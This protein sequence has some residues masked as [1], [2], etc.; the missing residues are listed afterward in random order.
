MNRGVYC[1]IG[2]ARY[3]LLYNRIAKERADRECKT[4]WEARLCLNTESGLH[5]LYTAAS[6][7][8]EGGELARRY[9]GYGNGGIPSAPELAEI[10]KA[11]DIPALRCAV[12]ECINAGVATEQDDEEIDLELLEIEREQRDRTD[13]DE[14]AAYIKLGRLA[15]LTEKET[16]LASI[17]TVIDL[18]E[19]YVR[20]I[21]V[22]KEDN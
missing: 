19:Q 6:A 21:G 4:G 14:R 17:G 8:I 11:R 22:K 13:A 20:M 16:L 5:A 9:L 10:V 1:E 15:G 12:Y 2:G 18:F 3:Y 7:L